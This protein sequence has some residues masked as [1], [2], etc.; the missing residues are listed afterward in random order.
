MAS[1]MNQTVCSAGQRNL[2][3]T[4]WQCGSLEKVKIAEI[5]RFNKLAVMHG[6]AMD[7]G[8]RTPQESRHTHTVTSVLRA[9]FLNSST[10]ALPT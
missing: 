9:Q 10:H 7:S 8:I 2:R 1:L 3:T 4:S 6:R 5:E